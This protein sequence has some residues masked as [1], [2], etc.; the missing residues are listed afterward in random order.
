[1]GGG[2]KISHSGTAM[3]KGGDELAARDENVL[4]KEPRVIGRMKKNDRSL[5]ER[6]SSLEGKS[7]GMGPA[8][9]KAMAV[10]GGLLAILGGAV[11]KLEKKG[12]FRIN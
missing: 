12:S 9:C 1:V 3:V 10:A 11:G 6:R 4:W 8:V 7:D 5:D 2:E